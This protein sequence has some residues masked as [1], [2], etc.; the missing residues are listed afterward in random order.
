L[1][2]IYG[3]EEGPAF[4]LPNGHAFFIGSTPVTAIYIPSGNTSPGTWKKGPS[5][6]FSVGNLGA[7]D[8]P[9]AMLPN[10]KILC[11][12]SPTPNIQ[13]SNTN[14]FTTPTYFYEYDYSQGSIGTF[15]PVNTPGGG[16]SDN[17]PT[18]PMRMLDLPDG[19]VLLTDGSTVYEYTPTNGTPLSS[20]QP[21]I[22][23]V[24]WNSDGTLTITGVLFNG[25]SQGAAYGDDAQMDSN[26]PIVR[27]VGGGGVYYGTTY[28]WSSTSVQSPNTVT[29]QV[30][31]PAGVLLNPGAYSMYVIA[32]G[33]P[34]APV[35][36]YGPTWVD[37]TY[38]GATQNGSYV[39][40]YKTMAGGIGAV[41]T[42][43]TIAINGIVQPSKSSET[44]SIMKAM[45]I[46]TVDGPS[47]VGN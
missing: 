16:A 13:G 25:N 46:I 33:N 17:A 34:S 21:V 9:A 41:T 44:P 37:F 10:G 4:L 32:N 43:G 20:G 11:A 24:A 31:L 23:N 7:P 45:N 12:L 6:S 8:A 18:Y 3:G 22:N 38:Q 40:P 5:M 42:G 29:A 2:D 36:F 15:T 27:F 1:Y 26:F 19:G 14:I 30:S 47:T 28:N 35:T 39:N